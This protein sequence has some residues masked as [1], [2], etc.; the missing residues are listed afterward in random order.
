MV[1]NI[2]PK[3]FQFSNFGPNWTKASPPLIF[4]RDKTYADITENF[5]EGLALG[6]FLVNRAGDLVLVRLTIFSFGVPRF[7]STLTWRSRKYGC[8]CFMNISG[9]KPDRGAPP[10]PL[11]N[12]LCL[13]CFSG[14][15]LQT[16][17]TLQL[18]RIFFSVFVGSVNCVSPGLYQKLFAL[19]LR[20]PRYRFSKQRQYRGCCIIFRVFFFIPLSI[21]VSLRVF[22]PLPP[23]LLDATISGTFLAYSQTQPDRSPSLL[24]PQSHNYFS[25]WK[26]YQCIVSKERTAISTEPLLRFLEVWPMLGWSC[27]RGS[28]IGGAGDAIY[29]N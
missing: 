11:A 6:W 1:S 28:I 13:C 29:Q 16:A 27:T 14:G 23:P 12:C 2:L 10:A 17:C 21:P 24:S 3:P 4:L 9:G 19:L 20:F 26:L 22:Q 25:P 18:S 7:N 15:W 5:C 8:F